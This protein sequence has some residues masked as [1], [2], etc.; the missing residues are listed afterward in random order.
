MKN[1][2]Y[3]QKFQEN[4]I[5]VNNIFL[6]REINNTGKKCYEIAFLQVLITLPDFRNYFL[7]NS[8]DE[9]NQILCYALKEFIK[10]YKESDKTLDIS[11]FNKKIS[12][13][14]TF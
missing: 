1:N 9:K 8:F 7:N 3:E 13:I 6:I 12:K 5:E 2:H 11:E 4:Q 10:Y 14:K